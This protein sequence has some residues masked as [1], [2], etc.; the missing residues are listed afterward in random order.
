MVENAGDPRSGV[1]DREMEIVWVPAGELNPAEYN[2]RKLSKAE[3]K[4]LKKSIE[5]YGMVEPIVVNSWEERSNVIIGGHQ[6]WYI[7]QDMKWPE[8]PVVY[9]EIDDLEREREL[10]LRLN[11]N[12]GQWDSDL[13][14]AF[15]EELL[16]EVGFTDKELSAIFDTDDDDDEEGEVEFSRELQEENNYIVLSFDNRIDWLRL[17]TVFPL[18]TTKS[19]RSRKGFEQKGIG[20]VVD[21]SEFLD[22]LLGNA[23]QEIDPEE[24]E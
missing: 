19:S 18:P 15:G 24:E 2:P 6:R 17:L 23:W 1:M 16:R 12:T 5:R 8:V 14:P 21:G 20:R 11:R 13:L 9:I 3:A 10:N 22:T 7:L 4:Q